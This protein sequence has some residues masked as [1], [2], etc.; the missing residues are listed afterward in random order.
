VTINAV[1]EAIDRHTPA[2]V[3]ERLVGNFLAVGQ[4]ATT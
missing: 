3:R 4:R 1:G 2:S